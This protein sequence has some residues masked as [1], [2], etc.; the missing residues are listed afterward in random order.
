MKAKRVVKPLLSIV[1]ALVVGAVVIALM[2]Q[3]PLYIYSTMLQGAFGSPSAVAG[4]LVKTTTMIFVGL[5]YGFAY[6]CGLI[7][8][9]IEGQLYMGALFSAYTAIYLNL[10][11]VL[12]IPVCLAAGFI[13][14]GIW[15]GIATGLFA[16]TDI[17]PVAKWDGLVYGGDL[18]LFG[19]QLAS[20]GVTIA[21]AVVGTLICAGIV[22]IFTKL[23]VDPRSEQVGLDLSEH[24]ERAY[25]SFN[26]LDD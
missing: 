1:L 18:R 13:G 22:R 17:N 21:L 19:A 3:N 10:P 2:G 8:I 26:G 25:P 12:E 15:G 7:N 11:A 20:I 5:S 4:T 9:G 16:R 14:G 23:R 24:G 6:K